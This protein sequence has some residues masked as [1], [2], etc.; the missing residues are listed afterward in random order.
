MKKEINAIRKDINRLEELLY[1]KVCDLDNF[2]NE[3]ECNNQVRRDFRN[4][5]PVEE[6]NILCLNC[7]GYIEYNEEEWL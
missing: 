4:M 6:A 3:C 5:T 2:D 7:G 1:K